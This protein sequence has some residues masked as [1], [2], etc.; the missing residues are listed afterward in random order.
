MKKLI[1]IIL[2]MVCIGCCLMACGGNKVAWL[3][4]GYNFGDSYDQVEKARDGFE[5]AHLVE[6]EV[7]GGWRMVD[8]LSAEEL[9]TFYGIEDAP[10]NNL[11][12]LFFDENKELYGVRVR[13]N[14][15]TEAELE[16]LYN[17][18][19][20]YYYEL[21]DTE[22]ET[23]EEDNSLDSLTLCTITANWNTDDIKIEIIGTVL[24]TVNSVD[25]TVC[26]PA[27]DLPSLG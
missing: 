7:N 4:E 24:G 19:Y 11:V 26:D 27:H 15:E 9:E 1:A 8:S 14:L 2:T 23:S 6:D 17:A 3:P 18:L 12:F 21:T 25:M 13:T 10:D 5:G 22:A 20:D 16:N